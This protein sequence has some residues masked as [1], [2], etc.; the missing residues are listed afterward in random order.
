MSE[1][2][3]ARRGVPEHSEE[4]VS[5]ENGGGHTQTMLEEMLHQA[6]EILRFSADVQRRMSEVGVDGIGGVLSLYSQLRGAMDKVAL[7]EIDAS[8]AD[9]ARLVETMQTRRDELQRMK[10]LKRTFESGQ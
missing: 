8:A 1:I 7:S 5:P 10:A 2:Y 3:D 4:H 9:V 6:E